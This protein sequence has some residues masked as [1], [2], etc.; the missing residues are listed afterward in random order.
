MRISGNGAEALEAVRNDNPDVVLV[1]IGLP[2]ESG[3]VVGARIR[4]ESPEA[5]VIAVTALEDATVVK[6]AA[7]AGF[8]AYLS[9]DTN[10]AAFVDAIKDAR[11]GVT[12]FPRKSINGNG[13]GSAN[14][15]AALLAR[16]L[17]RR[18]REVLALLSQGATSA[19]IAE[20]LHIAPNTVRTHVQSILSKL[21]VHSRLQA[22]AFA[23]R[24][25]IVDVGAGGS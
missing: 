18:E 25:G 19:R 8:H 23:I 24:N 6:E 13:H 14:P 11:S 5:T 17:T 12:L 15:D 4:Q 20:Q 16:Q 10:L 22:A 1:D 2:G 9:K 3:L 7:R 21:Q